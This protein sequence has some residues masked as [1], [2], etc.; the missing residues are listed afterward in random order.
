MN[1]MMIAGWF[2]MPTIA[3]TNEGAMR[4][5]R[6]RCREIGLNYDNAQDIIVRDQDGNDLTKME[7]VCNLSI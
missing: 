3:E 6:H 4:D 5:F 1:E 2:Y 7:R